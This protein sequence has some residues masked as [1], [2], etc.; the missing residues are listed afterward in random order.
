LQIWKTYEENFDKNGK[1]IGDYLHQ[2][3]ITNKMI[4]FL[5]FK[6]GVFDQKQI[7]IIMF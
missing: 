5:I 1:H 6:N 3:F 4:V 2:D 7:K